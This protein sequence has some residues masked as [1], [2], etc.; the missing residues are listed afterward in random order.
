MEKEWLCDGD[1]VDALKSFQKKLTAWNN[2]TFGHI[3]KRKRRV[4]SQLEGV[5]RAL[6]VK[7]SKGSIK[8]E[9]KLRGEWTDILLQEFPWYHQSRVDW[10]RFGDKKT[11]FFHMS[12][13]IHR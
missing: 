8:F 13:L 6:D 11:K 4:R 3:L 12:T 9:A 7:W 5:Q 1:S 10:I 2:D